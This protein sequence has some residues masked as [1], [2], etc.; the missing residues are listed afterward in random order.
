MRWI[1]LLILTTFSNT[2]IQAQ[3]TTTVPDS[4]TLEQAIATALQ[5]NFDI[6]LARNDSAIAAI[7]YSYR[8]AAFLPQLNANGS[9]LYNR[10][11]QNVTL[12]DGTKR[13]RSGLKTANTA[14]SVGLNW[15]VFDGLRMFATRE[16]AAEF[17]RFGNLIIKEQINNT[18]A[19]VIL[20]Y[21]SIVRASLQLRVIEEQIAL[22]EDRYRLAKY[23]FEIGAG[24]KP[25]MLQAQIDL[26]AQKG[27]Q[28]AQLASIEL[29]KQNLNRL[30]NVMPEV[31]YTVSDTIVVNMALT[32]ADLQSGLDETNPQL[33]LARKNIDIADLTLQERR[34]ERWPTIALNS[35]YNFTQNENNSVINP[36][37][38]LSSLNKGFNYGLTASVPLFN[39]F[40]TR[41]LIR[42]AEQS[43]VYEQTIYENQRS[44]VS[45]G[46]YNAYRNYQLQK[47]VVVL[48]ESNIE[49]TKENLFIARERYR[50]AATT[51][52]ELREAQRSLQEAYDRLISARYNMKVAET[53][54]LRLR[55]SFV[56]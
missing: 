6:Q 1:V 30:M 28:L 40:N 53:E 51:F 41:R 43:I 8:N 15:V 42:Q 11:N 9:V 50:L 33:R 10:N 21:Y 46:L 31:R 17:L 37:Q 49:L 24:V 13:N 27:A 18:V 36:A 26:N 22:N 20:N 4:L 19:D 7:D 29:A 16:K 23:R 39:R 2:H 52:L 44:L 35:A 54:L 25:D 48:E 3:S 12:A 5:N 47:E 56:R 34:A 32:M 55:G 14:A 45:T 38:P